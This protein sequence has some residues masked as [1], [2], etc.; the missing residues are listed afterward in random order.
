MSMYDRIYIADATEAQELGFTCANGHVLR[1]FQTKD[2]DDP[3]MAHYLIGQGRIWC[4][5]SQK[6]RGRRF[7]FLPSSDLPELL[8]EHQAYDHKILSFTGS[9]IIYAEC[10]TCAPTLILGS[11]YDGGLNVHEHHSFNEF[12]LDVLS[13]VIDEVTAV[14]REQRADIER[15]RG[16]RGER[17]LADDDPIVVALR[18]RRAA[19]AKDRAA[20]G[21][22]LD[23]DDDN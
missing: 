15:E 23:D 4:R 10:R 22:P 19:E 14:K 12:R 5:Q 20:R 16:Q 11:A 13:G 2:L 3:Y 8:R 6:T 17:V 18:E 1:G 21:L 7:E 9:A